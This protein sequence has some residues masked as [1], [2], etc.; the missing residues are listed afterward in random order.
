MSKWFSEPCYVILPLLTLFSC[1]S[2][3]PD[4]SANTETNKSATP[5]ENKADATLGLASMPAQ[6]LPA[7]S[8]AEMKLKDFV[9]KTE[10]EVLN[11]IGLKD[12]DTYSEQVEDL[13]SY[14]ERSMPSSERIA[15][16]NRCQSYISNK[17]DEVMYPT[18]KSL[19][20]LPLQLERQAQI[21]AQARRAE[22][23]T[24]END[25][26]VSV[27]SV[28]QW[29]SLS[30]RA[31]MDSFLRIDP[32]SPA[33]LTK[34]VGFAASTLEDC[35]FAGANAAIIAR[36][37]TYFPNPQAYAAVDT[38][39]P[40]VVRCL[41]VS[42]EGFERT[43][44]RV[45][46]VR[47]L[48]NKRVEARDALVRALGA[49]TT[50]EDF[51]TLFWLGAL[52]NQS[53]ELSNSRQSE[54][55]EEAAAA[56]NASNQNQYW[57]TLV[58]RYPL[59]YHG[60]VASH[61]MGIDP[62]ITMN[63]NDNVKLSRRA[64]EKWNEFDAF[65]FVFDLLISR[66]E[67]SALDS[68]S[69]FAERNWKPTNAPTSLYAALCQNKAQN[70]RSSFIFLNQYMRE[71]KNELISIDL[72]NLMFPRPY[73]N[74]IID[75]ASNIDPLLVMALIRQESAFDPFAR[76]GANARGLMQLLP[77]TAKTMRSISSE[78]LY[79]PV[80]NIQ[81]GSMYMSRLLKKYNGRVEHVLASYNAGGR[82]V[83][84]WR[85][86]FDES[87]ILLFSDLIPFKETRT[88]VSIILRNNYWYGRLMVASHDKLA[89]KIKKASNDAT[90]RASTVGH[91][92]NVAWTSGGDEKEKPKSV[93]NLFTT[94]PNMTVDD[95]VK[96]EKQ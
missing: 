32:S 27:R 76:S 67:A 38:L 21:R 33:E 25:S 75:H 6:S 29:P 13:V 16:V 79:E 47:V 69:K 84:K 89:E 54:P 68:W 22:R 31:F 62:L 42:D 63:Q 74:E 9:F 58:K 2:T 73:A 94:L 77:S 81:L 87:N 92:L 15:L 66:N 61:S 86:R 34:Y 35:K 56:T 17:L 24:K 19:S 96:S 51:R 20:C 44:L 39:Y 55:S 28:E 72:L 88:Y 14:I 41:N 53:P 46:L 90:W 59:S 26:L 78:G 91:L 11:E 50:N 30:G 49:T 43:H 71:S 4:I 48:Q 52:E 60:V 8:F 70:Y 23:G 64:G 80:A 65:A 18:V 1:R 10:T 5:S 12:D 82:N 95:K 37:E 3:T 83:D 36:A 7:S 85:T 40:S 45:G 93:A 57:N